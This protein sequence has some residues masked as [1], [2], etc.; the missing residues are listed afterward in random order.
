MKRNDFANKKASEIIEVLST[1]PG[2]SITSVFDQASDNTEGKYILIKDIHNN[3]M[4]PATM[5][6]EMLLNYHR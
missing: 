2:N 6:S 1:N 4:M 5:A 3:T